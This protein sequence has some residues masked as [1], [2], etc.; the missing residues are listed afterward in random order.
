MVTAAAAI[1]VDPSA[2]RVDGGGGGGVP[3]PA[4]P[5][6]SEESVHL[7]TAVQFPP[8]AL[9][10]ANP[11]KKWALTDFEKTDRTGGNG[12]LSYSITDDQSTA[13]GGEPE[14]VT[15]TAA[16]DEDGPAATT[17]MTTTKY[18]ETYGGQA[19]N[20]AFAHAS[21]VASGQVSY[22]AAEQAGDSAASDKPEHE[23]TPAGA[24]VPVAAAPV[25]EEV[26]EPLPPSA[27]IT[28]V[29]SATVVPSEKQTAAD[30]GKRPYRRRYAQKDPPRRYPQI[31]LTSRPLAPPPVADIGGLPLVD[32]VNRHYGVPTVK[33]LD[34][35]R[36]PPTTLRQ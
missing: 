6:A 36:G 1:R 15:K 17:T 21:D 14:Q 19:D 22:G 23:H 29:P 20:G 3:L 11:E 16:V 5:M 33:P 4:I 28:A 13:T 25:R 35:R 26:S 27:T 18:H 7:L 2:V 34:S 8:P 24:A 31:L 12:Q 32:Y 9:F 10:F 30:D